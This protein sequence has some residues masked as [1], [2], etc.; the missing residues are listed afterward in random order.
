MSTMRAFRLFHG[1]AL[2]KVARVGGSFSAGIVARWWWVNT[3]VFAESDSSATSATPSELMPPPRLATR[4]PPLTNNK[5]VFSTVFKPY[6]LGEIIP[7]THDV[8]L[9]RF[10]LPT[11]EDEF[12]LKP[13]STLQAQFKTGNAAVEQCQRFYTPVSANG[14]KGFFDL[15][16][17]RKPKGRMT[18]HL[19]G[20]HVGDTLNFRAVVFKVQYWP[21]RWQHVGMIAGG[22][23]F[24]PMLQVIR[25]A[26]TEP[27]DANGVPDRTKLSFL[28]CNRTEKHILLK[29]LFDD[30]ARRFP[31]RF[32][33]KYAVDSLVNKQKPF[34]GFVGYVTEE[35]ARD[36]MPPPGN[37][38]NIVLVC[39]PDK[40]L[41]HVAGF[42]MGSGHTMSGSLAL[43]PVAPDIAN[44]AQIGGVLGRL[45]YD[46]ANVYK[47]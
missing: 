15:I 3:T 42:P 20:L 22:T 18:D 21:N 28:Y 31:E 43:Q 6:V 25:H 37:G 36:L 39:G 2:R 38:E 8:A 12:N 40:L 4:P 9:F 7:M 33:V 13:C 17:K 41:N 5:K 30:L 24:T 29:G 19:F 32:R 1:A 14:T 44:L 23:G 11:E 10:L 35:M 45:G 34:D 27:L 16:V 26:L 46:A 47:F